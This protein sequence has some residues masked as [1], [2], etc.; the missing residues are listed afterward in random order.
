[1]YAPGGLSESCKTII[2]HSLRDILQAE[3]QMDTKCSSVR[4]ATKRT[5]HN[6][7]IRQIMTA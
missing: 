5:L 1:M 4:S 2:L 6:A 7:A 3:A